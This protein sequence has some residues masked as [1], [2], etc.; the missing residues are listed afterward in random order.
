M[1]RVR[2]I[3]AVVLMLAGLLSEATAHGIPSNQFKPSKSDA[4]IRAIGHRNIAKGPNFYSFEKE[5]DLGKQLAKEVNASANFVDDPE[6]TLY[7]DHLGQMIAQHSDVRMPVTLHVIDSDEISAFTL[8]GGYQYITRGLLL[9]LNAEAELAGVL[10]FGI[11]HTALRSATKEATQGDIAQIATIPTTIFVPGGWPMSGPQQTSQA[12]KLM[13]PLTVL[14]W[15][16]QDEL[17]ADYFGLQY[18][19]ITGY[20]PDCYVNLVERILPL[21]SS[22]KPPVFSTSPPLPERLAAMHKEIASILPKRN[23]A[24]VSTPVFTDFQR[25]VRA[26]KPAKPG[27]QH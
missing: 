18:V 22:D 14:K 9:H 26:W 15:K 8:P 16:Q 25:R 20:D 6:I 24:V 21:V 1:T 17:A 7:V 11:A 19:Y 23:D 13:I 12:M 3:V 10:A 4:N 5:K 27:E 2:Y